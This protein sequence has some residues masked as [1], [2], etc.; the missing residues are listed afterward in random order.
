MLYYLCNRRI[1]SNYTIE[2]HLKNHNL[3]DLK[4]NLEV[5]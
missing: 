4:E 3:F 2:E 5:M 1:L